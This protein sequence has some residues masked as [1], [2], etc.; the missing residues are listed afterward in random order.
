MF[1]TLQ[2]KHHKLSYMRMFARHFLLYAVA[3]CVC[4]SNHTKTFIFVGFRLQFM[5]ISFFFASLFA[6]DKF[7]LLTEAVIKSLSFAANRIEEWT[8]KTQENIRSFCIINFFPF[9]CVFVCQLV[10][11]FLF[12]CSS[13]VLSRP[14]HCATNMINR[15]AWWNA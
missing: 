14:N 9:I 15:D 10:F 3:L 13:V 6:F 12:W 8:G 7:S 4:V 1:H 5:F 11:V 2:R